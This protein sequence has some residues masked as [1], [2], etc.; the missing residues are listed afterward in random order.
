MELRKIKKNPSGE[1]PAIRFWQYLVSIV[2]PVLFIVTPVFLLIR[3][4]DDQLR[5]THSGIE[6]VAVLGSL[7]EGMMII[8][9]SRGLSELALFKGPVFEAELAVLH[10][11]FLE[12]LAE[13]EFHDLASESSLHPML[14]ESRKQANT[15]FHVGEPN[16]IEDPFALHTNL[17]RELLRLNLKVSASSGLILD[18]EEDSYHLVDIMVNHLPRLTEATGR[19]RAK[20]SRLLAAGEWGLSEEIVL[21]ESLAGLHSHLEGLEDKIEVIPEIHSQLSELLQLIENNQPLRLFVAMNHQLIDGQLPLPGSMEYFDSASAAMA[22]YY[23]PL[24]RMRIMLAS[25]LGERQAALEQL[26]L[27]TMLG[28]FIAVLLL[29]SFNTAFYLRNRRAF[30]RIEELAITDMLTGLYNRRYL[31]L[32]IEQELQRA[33][34][35]GKSF[36]L[37]VLD[38]DHFKPY[39]DKFGHQA[40][41]EVLRRVAGVMESSLQRSGDFLFRI[42]GEEFCFFFTGSAVAEAEAMAEKVRKAVEGLGIEHP[43]SRSSSVV[44]ISVGG[45]FLPVVTEALFDPIMK[46]ADDL[47]YE[48]PG[49]R[50]VSGSESDGNDKSEDDLCCRASSIASRG[51][52]LSSLLFSCSVLCRFGRDMVSHLSKPTP[53]TKMNTR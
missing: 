27:L 26:K 53:T 11:R 5:Q 16:K 4:L 14:R 44:T 6:G 13:V 2:I 49:R 17:I 38:I 10:G 15:L 22:G 33:K 45:V 40:G 39:N 12:I 28:T 20:G 51:Y 7:H 41:D 34:R 8:Q 37:G 50:L 1:M 24:A 36:T 47:L 42:G 48:A 30:R 43:G 52:P 9:R 21:R 25:Q 29:F 35:D 18:P 46:M 3:N 31:G 32:V 19:L 23:Q